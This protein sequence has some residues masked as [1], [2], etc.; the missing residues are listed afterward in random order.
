MPKSTIIQAKRKIW[1]YKYPID[2][3]KQIDSLAMLVAEKMNTNPQNGDIFAFFS[4][5]A[6]KIKLLTW[7][8]TGFVLVYKRLEVGQFY[9]PQ[10]VGSHIEL[11]ATQ[12]RWLLSGT[13]VNN[14]AQSLEYSEYF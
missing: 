9:I 5:A 10:Y 3:R 2:M 1:M 4:H 7:D 6:D 8:G 12:L 13:N 11:S 14:Y